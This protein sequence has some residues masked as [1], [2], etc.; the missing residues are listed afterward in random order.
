MNSVIEVIEG[1]K[2]IQDDCFQQIA[3]G[4]AQFAR[5]DNSQQKQNANVIRSVSNRRRTIST[6]QR[7][8]VAEVSCAE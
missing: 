7:V 8:A 2:F 4:M 3:T 1:R 5:I 6:G